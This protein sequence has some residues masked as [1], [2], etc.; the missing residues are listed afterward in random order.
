MGLVRGA[1]GL[2]AK[3]G[4]LFT[5]CECCKWW[6]T[7]DY[8]QDPDRCGNYPY[9]CGPEKK[10]ESIGPF[11]PGDCQCPAPPPCCS[12]DADCPENFCC[13]EDGSCIPCEDPPDPPEGN[14]YCCLP[15]DEWDSI[16]DPDRFPSCHYGMCE[17]NQGNPAPGLVMSGPHTTQEACLDQC[18]S[19][20]CVPS[21]CCDTPVCQPDPDGPYETFKACSEACVNPPAGACVIT[22]PDYPSRDPLDFR[23][24]GNAN[25]TV[26]PYIKEW[27]INCDPGPSASGKPGGPVVCVHWVTKKG[28]PIRVQLLSDQLYPGTCEVTG[29]DIIRLDSQW[30]GDPECDCV[31][32]RPT[33]PLALPG[34]TKGK[35]IWR[36]KQRGITS[37]KIR[38]FSPCADSDW[39][40]T[41]ACHDCL[42]V[43]DSE[44][45]PPDCAPCG[46]CTF[47]DARTVLDDESGGP[48]VGPNNVNWYIVSQSYN[49][50]P[51]GD[52]SWNAGYPELL[53][54]CQYVWVLDTSS[55][56]CQHF[57]EA[58]PGVEYCPS[59]VC[60]RY[61]LFVVRC[62]GGDA[63]LE[64]ITDD[65]VTG[66][67]T[68][69]YCSDYDPSACDGTCADCRDFLDDPEVFCDP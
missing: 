64:D 4:A 63:T 53:G 14:W 59:I 30:Q 9:A 5:S 46:F 35:L 68:G 39:E 36:T 22:D 27:H 60:F 69:T 26:A 13:A 7:P 3:F 16:T 25:T 51:A 55:A 45:C 12:E 65:A 47:T 8:T 57:R 66:A 50:P 62:I 10:P 67:L 32:P 52:W 24:T 49:A 19:H 11:P 44:G 21:A 42:D 38:I 58:E 56:P 2:L 31:P 33:P 23:E 40:Y 29:T 20:N 15:E 34:D 1:G 17:D 41:V 37:F 43:P 6:C 48:C 61:R 54:N 18:R 28:N